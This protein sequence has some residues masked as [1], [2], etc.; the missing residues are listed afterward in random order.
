[1][2]TATAL[3]LEARILHAKGEADAA[4]A[5]IAEAA[6]VEDAMPLDFGP[7]FP[8]K[9]VHELWGEMLL[10]LGSAGEAQA[11]FEKALE[12]A[13]R[14]ARSLLGLA[15]A[16]QTAGDE[17]AADEARAAL[18]AVWHAAD[19]DVQRYLSAAGTP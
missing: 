19:A 18:A 4:L 9:P 15:R 12:R 10:D 11:Q 1:G 2:E 7:P 14:R 13:P 8:V 5:R 16:A 6:A 17:A 3:S